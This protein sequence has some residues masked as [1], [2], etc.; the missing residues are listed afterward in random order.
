MA[1]RLLS[2]LAHVEVADARRRTS[3]CGSTPTCSGSRSRAGGR[4]RSISAAGATASIHTLQLTEGDAPGLGHIAWRAQGPE[5]LETAV[6]R[7]EAAGR[8]RGLV[9]GLDR[10]RARR[11]ATA[12]RAGTCTS[13]SGRSS[14]TRRRPGSSRRSRTGRSATSRA[15]S[16]RCAASTTSPS[17]PPIPRADAAL[18]PRDARPPLHGVH[19][20]PRPAGLRRLRDDDRLRAQPRPGP[21][22]GSVA[23][24]PAGSTTSRTGSTRARS[25]CASP[26][27]S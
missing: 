9:R 1:E 14:A 22:L 19:G 26:T 21:R 3:R 13:C 7:I 11:T 5:Q 17:R 15:G 4:S 24:V 25:C 8:R 10:P 2:Q 12:A 16:L 27:C 20:D 6:A 23:G 18:V